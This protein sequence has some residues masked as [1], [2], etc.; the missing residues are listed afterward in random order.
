VARR[1]RSTS[2]AIQRGNVSEA[3]IIPI[4]ST[5]VLA[6]LLLRDHGILTVHF[7]SRREQ[8]RCCSSLSRPRRSSSSAATDAFASA[9]DTSLDELGR[10]L[11]DPASVPELLLGDR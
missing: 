6:M 2:P 8:R 3:P 9:V 10:R 4:E 1:R 5:A 11:A 7:A